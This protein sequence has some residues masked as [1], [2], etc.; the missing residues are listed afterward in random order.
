MSSF[1][2]PSTFCARILIERAL[3][4]VGEKSRLDIETGWGK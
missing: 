3:R 2:A 1:D 4:A